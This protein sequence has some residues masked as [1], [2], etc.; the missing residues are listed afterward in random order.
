MLFLSSCEEPPV[1]FSGPQ[2]KGSFPRF[3]LDMM[4]QGTFL[5]DSDSAMLHV[6][7][8][9]IYKEKPFSFSLTAEEIAETEGIDLAG[10]LLLRGK[11]S[12]RDFI[13]FGEIFQIF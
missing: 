11:F 5:C 12:R 2:P 9:L 13:V 8:R 3:S 10:C 7:S 4:S 1:V 6:E